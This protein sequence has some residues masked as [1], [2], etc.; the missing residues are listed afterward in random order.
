MMFGVHA[1]PVRLFIGISLATARSTAVLRLARADARSA[2]ALP[3]RRCRW[4]SLGF[5]QGWVAQSHESRGGPDSGGGRGAR[6]E[7]RRLRRRLR[8]LR[9]GS[10]G[11]RVGKRRFAAGSTTPTPSTS[12]STA[13][14]PATPTVSL[15]HGTPTRPRARSSAAP[16]PSTWPR[17][18]GSAA[19]T[20]WPKTAASR[21]G[22]PSRASR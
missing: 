12:K 7:R 3:V 18:Y 14:S 19:T 4:R 11:G 8:R 15:P 13:S 6:G 17:L 21:S 5:A 9:H 22:R 20:S 2:A 10:R 16:M 1:P